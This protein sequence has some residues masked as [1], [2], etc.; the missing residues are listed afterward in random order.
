MFFP[1][2][3]N[4]VTLALW[5]PDSTSRAAN[6]LAKRGSGIPGRGHSNR[7]SGRCGR[8]PDRGRELGLTASLTIRE[9][10]PDLHCEA[11]AVRDVDAG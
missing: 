3:E 10:E 5:V 4:K 8:L 11:T 2:G 9:S 7:P 1:A 6:H